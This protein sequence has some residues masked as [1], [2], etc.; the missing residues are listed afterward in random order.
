MLSPKKKARRKQEG[1]WQEEKKI[2]V[3]R[4]QNGGEEARETG[5]LDRVGHQGPARGETWRR[6]AK[7]TVAVLVL[8]GWHRRHISELTTVQVSSQ[9]KH[10]AELKPWKNCNREQGAPGWWGPEVTVT[11]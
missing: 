5:D 10:L 2:D 6:K 8:P 9:K 1:G 3:E 7:V 4:N 11:L